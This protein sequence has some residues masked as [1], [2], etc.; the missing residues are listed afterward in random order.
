MKFIRHAFGSKVLKVN[1]L[2]STKTA[3]YCLNI[4]IKDEATGEQKSFALDDCDKIE[5]L[6]FLASCLEER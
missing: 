6:Q 1:Y 5:L 3:P 2:P 4:E